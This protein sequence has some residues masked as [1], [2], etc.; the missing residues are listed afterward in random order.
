MLFHPQ[1]AVLDQ[2]G[3]LEFVVSTSLTMEGEAAE[4][5]TLSV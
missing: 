2:S 3:H 5:C 4:S 1:F